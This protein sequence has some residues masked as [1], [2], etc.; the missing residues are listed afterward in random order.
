MSTNLTI[1]TITTNIEKTNSKKISTNQKIKIYRI[2]K[3]RMSITL[4]NLLRRSILS[5]RQLL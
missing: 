3:L 1:I 5:N 4:I 2:L